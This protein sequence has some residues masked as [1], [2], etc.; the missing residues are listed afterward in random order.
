[1]NSN[2]NSMRAD[3]TS[4]EDQANHWY[5]RLHSDKCTEE[6]IEK[7]KIWLETSF[8]HRKAYKSVEDMCQSVGG[9][10]RRPEIAAYREQALRFPCTE[11]ASATSATKKS[12]PMAMPATGGKKQTGFSRWVPAAVAASLLMFLLVTRLQEYN[13]AGDSIYQTQIGEQKTVTLT[14]GSTVILDTQTR[15]SKDFSKQAR[16]IVLEQ[17]QARFHVAKD[18]NRPFM[19]IAG[20]G[21]ITALGTDFV[22]KKDNGDVL[23]TLIEGEVA[24]QKE[25]FAPKVSDVKAPRLPDQ[26]GGEKNARQNADSQLVHQSHGKGKKYKISEDLENPFKNELR[27]TAGQQ[28]AIN[29]VG[30]SRTSDVNVKQITSWQEGKLV[31]EDD[32]LAQVLKDLNRYSKSKIVLGDESLASV[33]ISG[34]FKTG[35]NIRIVQTLKAFFSM[36][37]SSDRYGNLILEPITKTPPG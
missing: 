16:R 32:T 31:F 12:T 9:F 22:V 7:C 11:G 8:A 24:V 30:I 23:V 13:T 2:D 37:V 20:E 29:R 33:R 15:I 3:K 26:S 34:V 27:M 10:G 1:M 19:V 4:V 17:G 6:D 21:K 14:D 36:R 25:K 18:A 28:V 5:V 35:D